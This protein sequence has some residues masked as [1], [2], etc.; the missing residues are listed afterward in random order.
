MP[1]K[2]LYNAE[3]LVSQ[4]TISP[5]REVPMWKWIVALDRLLRGEQARS[6]TLISGAALLLPVA[7]AVGSV[8]LMLRA[9]QRN[10]SRMLLT[11]FA[12]WVLSPFAVLVL[13][14]VV[15]KRW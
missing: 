2:R 6:P 8:F 9:G 7:G 1:A 3:L 11:L 14:N 10:D 5:S 13:A 15:S 4:T 12:I